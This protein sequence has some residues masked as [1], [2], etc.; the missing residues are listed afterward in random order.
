MTRNWLLG[1]AALWLLLLVAAIGLTVLAAHKDNLP[2]DER[3]TD[4]L[5]DF[6]LPGRNLSDFVQTVTGTEVV[7]ATGAAVALVL[8]QRGYRRQAVLLG[9]GLIVLAALHPLVKEI[10][11]RPRPDPGLVK[12]RSGFDSSSFPSGHVMSATFLYGTLLYF[13]IVLP[14]GTVPRLAVVAACLFLITMTPLTSIWLGVHWPSDVAGA[15]SWAFVLLL[16]IIVLD[17]SEALADP[18]FPERSLE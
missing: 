10:V 3:L 13:S 8:W 18:D 7:L 16:P 15:W 2:G 11:D 12:L 6:S 14:L 5:Q 4:W 17:R 1:A 9:A